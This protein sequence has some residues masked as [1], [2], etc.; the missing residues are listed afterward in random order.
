MNER[1]IGAIARMLAV[2]CCGGPVLVSA[3]GRGRDRGA[4]VVAFQ[5]PLFRNPGQYSSLSG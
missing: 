4:P 2:L 5:V 1:T 3:A